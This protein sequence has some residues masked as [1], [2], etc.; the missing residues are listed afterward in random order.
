MSKAQSHSEMNSNLFINKITKQKT[1][2]QNV[3]SQER[4]ND[5]DKSENEFQMPSYIDRAA[6]DLQS[7][8]SLG[9]FVITQQNTIKN[10]RSS[11]INNGNYE[12]QSK[13]QGKQE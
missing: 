8:N 10:T 13:L 11:S 1:H 2:H 6:H 7:V 3:V 9:G 4:Q 5:F 12:D